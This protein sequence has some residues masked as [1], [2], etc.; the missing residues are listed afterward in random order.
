MKTYIF[1]LAVFS[2]CAIVCCAVDVKRDEEKVKF[3]E[4]VTWTART[5]HVVKY[6]GGAVELRFTGQEVAE[7]LLDYAKK[8]A[9]LPMDVEPKL[10][11]CRDYRM[12]WMGG[13][14]TN[15]LPVEYIYDS[16]LSGPSRDKPIRITVYPNGRQP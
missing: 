16:K 7:A 5:N 8:K 13:P 12:G 14:G 9:A 4:E 6:S 3:L 15:S 11:D 2:V 10:Y 1:G